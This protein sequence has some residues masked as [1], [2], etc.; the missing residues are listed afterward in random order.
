MNKVFSLLVLFWLQIT[1]AAETEAVTT[2]KLVKGHAYSVTG[3]EEVMSLSWAREQYK[4]T[5]SYHRE[6]IFFSST[7]LLF[8]G[9]ILWNV[10][11]CC[12]LV[13]LSS[14]NSKCPCWRTFGV[15]CWLGLT[16][17]I[18]VYFIYLLACLLA[19]LDLL[20]ALPTSGFRVGYSKI[21]YNKIK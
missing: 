13:V 12:P 16:L 3:A 15:Y 6:P 9:G 11:I 18:R 14:H 2:Q 19:C 5:R 4:C 10:C 20:S 8:L 21:K 17:L 7:H 1:S